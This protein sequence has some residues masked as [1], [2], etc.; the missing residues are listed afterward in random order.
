MEMA[1]EAM[2]VAMLEIVRT[3]KLMSF[4]QEQVD[5][6]AP[7]LVAQYPDVAKSEPKRIGEMAKAM[8]M[9]QSFEIAFGGAEEAIERLI[10]CGALK[11]DELHGWKGLMFD[12][13]AHGAKSAA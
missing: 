1:K 6:L 13:L 3:G 10:R 8:V 9:A 2:R 11:E 12:I 7:L 5:K 4:A